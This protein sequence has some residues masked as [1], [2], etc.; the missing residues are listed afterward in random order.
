VRKL[1]EV[2][3]VPEVLLKEWLVLVAIPSLDLEINTNARVKF[4]SK[5]LGAVGANLAC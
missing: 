5:H 3:S 2:W 1:V 4:D